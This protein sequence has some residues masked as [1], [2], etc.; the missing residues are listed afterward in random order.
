MLAAGA[1][2]LSINT[3]RELSSDIK[4]NGQPLNVGLI[5]N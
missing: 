1:F 5:A 4:F 3:C 2:P